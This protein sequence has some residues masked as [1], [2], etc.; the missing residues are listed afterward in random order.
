MSEGGKGLE[1]RRFKRIKVDF[2]V[3]YLIREPM[4]VSMRVGGKNTKTIMFDLSEEG[5]AVKSYTEIPAGAVLSIDFTL[6]YVSKG[7]LDIKQ[8]MEIQGRVVNRLA[9]PEKSFRYGIH[10]EKIKP[11]DRRAIADFIDVFFNR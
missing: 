10:F 5:M 3:R 2:A 1:R 11:D 6:V 4:D 7:G 9:L 8:E